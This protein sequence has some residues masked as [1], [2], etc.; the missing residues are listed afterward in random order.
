M[1]DNN[2]IVS[3]EDVTEDIAPFGMDSLY[4]AMDLILNGKPANFDPIN[5]DEPPPY[6]PEQKAEWDKL[7]KELPMALD[8]ILYNSSFELGGYK[9][10]FHDRN[11]KKLPS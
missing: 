6:S 10:R 8:V 4:E 1:M 3:A 2:F 7:Y 5:G 9:T 11:W